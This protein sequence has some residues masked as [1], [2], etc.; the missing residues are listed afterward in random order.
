MAS[1]INYANFPRNERGKDTTQCLQRRFF[2]G[3]DEKSTLNPGRPMISALVGLSR[4]ISIDK[5]NWV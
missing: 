5:P 1:A 2:H 3:S 4:K